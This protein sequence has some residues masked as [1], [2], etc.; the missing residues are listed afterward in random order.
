[1]KETKNYTEGLALAGLAPWVGLAALLILW[2]P[3]E[4]RQ[5]E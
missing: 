4:G 5:L 1:V 3:N 2:R